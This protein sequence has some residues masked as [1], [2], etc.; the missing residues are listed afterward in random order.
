MK[1]TT[2]GRYTVN[3]GYSISR[4]IEDEDQQPFQQQGSSSDNKWKKMCHQVWKLIVKCK[5]KI[6][7]WKCLNRCLPT[8]KAIFQRTG[9]QEPW[10]KCC[11]EGEESIEHLF[12]HCNQAQLIWKF[13]PIHWEGLM[14]K[15]HNFESWWQ[16][17]L[18]AASKT[19]IEYHV[20]IAVCILW[21]ILK[22]GNKWLFDGIR[23]DFNFTMEQARNDCL[24]T[25]RVPRR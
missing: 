14:D 15:Q 12:F 25:K 10:C 24:N 13:A 5:L 18:K 2:N 4:K 7:L 20:T 16:G 6:I 1:H 19:G 11:G 3:S 22:C 8:N 23:H 17:I 21:M 9:K